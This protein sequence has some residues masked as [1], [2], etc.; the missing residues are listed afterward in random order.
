MPLANR[1][2]KYTQVV[3]GIRDF[4]HRFGRKPE[5]MW[6]PETAVDIETLERKRRALSK[7]VVEAIRTIILFHRAVM[8][9]EQ[10]VWGL[11]TTNLVDE[12]M[13]VNLG[14]NGLRLL[15]SPASLMNKG[16]RSRP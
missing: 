10:F 9:D 1:R 11:Y 14:P 12:R 8:E 6:L 4:E 3:W 13:I 7:T 2:D 5:G 16:N 15:A